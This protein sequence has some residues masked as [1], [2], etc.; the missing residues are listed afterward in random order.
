MFILQLNKQNITFTKQ[1]LNQIIN[2]IKEFYTKI[3]Q[4][5]ECNGCN[6]CLYGF[7]NPYWCSTS[8]YLYKDITRF[9]RDFYEETG[10]YPSFQ[11]HREAIGESIGEPIGENIADR[12]LIFELDI[13]D[14]TFEKELQIMETLIQ[15]RKK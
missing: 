7:G 10:N 6:W 3:I 11:I 13:L 8:G 14:N 4:E 2:T 12:I 5:H 9:L 1:E 15:N